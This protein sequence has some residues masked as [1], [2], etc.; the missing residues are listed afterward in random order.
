M[1]Q[2]KLELKP[3]AVLKQYWNDNEHFA[4]FFNAVLFQGEAVIKSQD[5]C[6]VDSQETTVVE[7][8]KMMRSMQMTRDVVKLCKHSN[9][10][11]VEFVLLGMES[12]EH[13]HY[14]M[15]MRVMGYDYIAYKKQY[16]ANAKS[17]KEAS[18]VTEDEYLSRMRK[19]DRFIPVITVV[20]YYGEKPWDA[21]TSLH[22][23]LVLED[24]VKPFVNDYKMQLV[25]ARKNKLH[26]HNI[27]NQDLF[28]LLAILLNNT[29]QKDLI[30]QAA[31]AYTKDHKVDKSVVITAA[32]AANCKL[33]YS[34][35]KTKGE[36]DMCTVFEETWQEGLNEGLERGIEQGV[37]QGENNL[38]CKMHRNGMPIRDIVILT[39]L[40]EKRIQEALRN[41]QDSN[42]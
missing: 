39:G 29:R 7:N 14:A 26:F 22:A 12:Q 9:K 40:T 16:D 31:I 34:Q 10:H 15:P 27:N 33:D 11:N 23:M 17:Y 8:K 1:V 38:I 35:M 25:E 28:Q 3:D 32:G 18:G 36:V 2:Q 30:K 13:I 37:S 42:E 6:D 41:G 20:V 21:A 4:D 19:A 5:L 24:V